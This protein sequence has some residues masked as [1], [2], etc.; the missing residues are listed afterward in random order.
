MTIVTAG[1]RRKGK[2]LTLN[3]MKLNRVLR[4]NKKKHTLGKLNTAGT[5]SSARDLTNGQSTTPEP[6]MT[7]AN[8]I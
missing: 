5:M 8:D 6:K 3:G 1:D 7:S 2:K 4:P